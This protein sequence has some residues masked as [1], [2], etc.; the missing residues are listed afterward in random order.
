[1]DNASPEPNFE[2][3][4][5]GHSNQACLTIL[6]QVNEAISRRN[7]VYRI[8]YDC[9]GDIREMSHYSIE[10]RV[11]RGI[12]HCMSCAHVGKYTGHRRVTA[13]NLPWKVASTRIPLKDLFPHQV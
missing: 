3:F 13:N 8:K 5:I 9:C 1:M 4:T 7:Q 11:R 12:R 6:S 2:R 10:I